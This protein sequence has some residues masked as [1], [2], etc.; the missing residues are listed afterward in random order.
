MKVYTLLLNGRSSDL[1]F[2]SLSALCKH[3]KIG[4]SNVSRGKRLL[5]HNGYLAEIIDLHVIKIK[6]RKDNLSSIKNAQD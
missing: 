6:G 4:Y 3:H 2:T 5:W 1:A